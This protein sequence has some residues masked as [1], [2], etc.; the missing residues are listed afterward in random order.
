LPKSKPLT[1]LEGIAETLL[2]PLCYRAVEAHRPDALVH[3]N[4]AQEII[5][6]LG[7]DPAHLKWRASQ[8]AFAMLRARQFDRWT[9]AFLACH[10]KAVVVEIGC[11]LDARFDRVDNGQVT[12]VDMDLPEVIAFRR[13]FFKDGTRRQ[14]AS[15]SVFDL[16]WME[17]IPD[18]DATL[19]LAEGVFPY[20]SE[21]EVRQVVAAIAERFPGSEM[22]VDALSPFMVRASALVPMFRGYQVRPRWEV[23]NPRAIESWSSRVSLLDEWTYFDAP[24]PRLASLRWMALLP[25]LRNMARVLR[26]GFREPDLTHQISL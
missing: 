7:I 19:F 26:L 16:D 11:G 12:W 25:S 23:S 15:H 2:I 9:K 1:G 20:F 22:V 5:D 8:Q 17:A 14:V 6:Q 3:D 10:P 18:S 4:R 24:E 21:N 13:R